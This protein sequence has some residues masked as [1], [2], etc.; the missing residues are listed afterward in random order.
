MVSGETQTS[1]LSSGNEANVQNQTTQT[2]Q[3]ETNTQ[4]TQTSEFKFPDNFDYRTI[5]P[6]DLK[7]DAT[8][9]KY[10]SL[11]DVFR[12]LPAAQKMI[13][14]DPATLVEITPDMA[15]DKMRAVMNRL[16]AAE[17]VDGYKLNAV[18]DAPEWLGPDQ[19]MAKWLSTKAH[20]AGI[21]VKTAQA[22]YEGFAGEM[23]TAMKAQE[24]AGLD[25]ANKAIT[26][27]K[28]KHGADFDGMVRRAK[29]AIEKLGGDPLRQALEEANLGVH[30]TVIEALANAGKLYE[31]D[32]GAGDKG[33]NSLPS[34]EKQRAL[35]LIRQS[36]GKEF[37]K[38]QAGR[39]KLQD[40]AQAIL[41]RISSGQKV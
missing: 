39:K 4:Q 14:K 25:M 36:H 38:D 9:T 10:K 20:E 37:D 23:M 29:L 26:Q 40:Q 8:W 19:H 12:A 17:N 24:A 2:T 33:G 13:G 34:E 22:L 5:V 35:D 27:M 16:G 41:A 6:A 15:P 21:P 7:E 1:V 3:T 11:E 32:T 28:E 30:P 31:E 18:K